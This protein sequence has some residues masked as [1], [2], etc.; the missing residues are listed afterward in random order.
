M[1]QPLGEGERTN[2]GA[3]IELGSTGVA[4]QRQRTKDKSRLRLFDDEI[5]AVLERRAFYSTV[6]LYCSIGPCQNRD[7][8]TARRAKPETRAGY[9]ESPFVP[10]VHVSRERLSEDDTDRHQHAV[11]PF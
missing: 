1:P 5:L 4:Q 2:R 3:I 6:N 11:Q 10:P 7:S 8:S 9:V